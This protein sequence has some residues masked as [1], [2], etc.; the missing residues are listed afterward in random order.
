M[1]QLS[2][3]RYRLCYSYSGRLNKDGMAPIALECRQDDRK[4]YISSKV[5]VYP[6]QWKRGMVVNHDNASKLTAYLIRWRNGIEELELDMLL[7]G[8]Q[9]TLYQLRD[10]IRTGVKT[11][12]TLKEFTESVIIP[13]SSR[14]AGTKRAYHYLVSSLENEYGKIKV[15]DLTYDFITRYRET[16]RRKGLSENTIKGRLKSLR[17]I[18]EE[19]RLRNIID[20]N[21]FDSITIGNMTPRVEYLERKDVE[22]LE[23]LK[24]TGRE[25]KVRDLFTFSCYTGL[26]FSDLSTLEEAELKD[27]ILRKKMKKTRQYVSIPIATL[28]WGKA[29]RIW[30]KYPDITELSHAASN[31]TFNKMIKD[32]G[33]KAGVKK[34]LHCHVGRKAFSNML[35]IMGMDRADI[36][37]LMGHTQEKT[38]SMF[39]IFN[40]NER[41][42]KSVKKLFKT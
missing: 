8:R 39:Y 7:K 12:A 28:F 10:A 22:K 42:K 5:L 36:K 17:C 32:I 11:S 9:V 37:T 2:K 1:Q 41:T 3:I 16:M 33:R 30:Q 23:R 18:L 35:N 31:T 20:S 26:R 25:E 19:A 13:D 29:L 27:G 21:P 40:D 15:Q 34:R 6:N 38:T 4:M 14:C 24:L